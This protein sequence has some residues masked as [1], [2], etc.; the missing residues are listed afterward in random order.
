FA[1]PSSMPT[2]SMCLLM[3]ISCVLLT[4][5]SRRRRVPSHSRSLS[6][7]GLMIFL[8]SW[9]HGSNWVLSGP[10]SRSGTPLR[11]WSRWLNGSSDCH[12]D[13]AAEYHVQSVLDVQHEITLKAGKNT[14]TPLRLFM[15]AMKQFSNNIADV[16]ELC[17]SRDAYGKE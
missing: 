6:G 2:R 8:P 9:P 1:A 10:F 14:M 7:T 4:T 11:S 12:L 13:R 17:G 16:R 15:P 5:R 3:K